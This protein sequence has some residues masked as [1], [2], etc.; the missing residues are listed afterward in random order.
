MS[1]TS[2]EDVL[3]EL[4][5]SWEHDPEWINDTLRNRKGQPLPV[6]ANILIALRADPVLQDCFAFDRMLQAPLLMRPLD[7]SE[8]FKPR[9][10]TDTDI[11]RFQEWLQHAGLRNVSKDV[12]HQAV[13]LRA[14]ERAFHPV[15]DY[16]NSLKWDGKTRV[17]SWLAKYLGAG[18][19]PYTEAVGRMFLISMVARIFEPG[20]KA[21]YML[22]LEGLQGTLKSAA[23]SVL[24]GQWFSDNLPDVSEGKDVSQ[25]LRGKWLLEI[26]EMHAMNRAETTLLKAFI[27]RPIERYRPSYGRCEVFEPRQCVFIGTTN[28]SAYLRDETGGRRFWPVSCGTINIETLT[29]STVRRSDATVLRWHT[30]VAGSQLRAQRYRS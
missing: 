8:D 16:L 24:A 14:D 5:S 30:M 4:G 20:C 2:G 17:K 27:T 22:V 6:L 7:P 15:R 10:L 11:A 23:C 3:I 13:G 18:A 21:D 12:M 1:A 9:P 26:S 25:H 29:R 19:T 28:K